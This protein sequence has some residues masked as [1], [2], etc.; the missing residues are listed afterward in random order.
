MFSRWAMLCLAVAIVFSV[1]GLMDLSAGVGTAM[2]TIVLL[3]LGLGLA[4]L[5]LEGAW[6]KR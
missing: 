1:F 6:R 4:L 3:L 5:G 2:R